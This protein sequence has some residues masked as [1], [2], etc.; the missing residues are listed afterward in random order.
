MSWFDVAER[1]VGLDENTVCRQRSRGLHRLRG[2][3]GAAVEGDR[4]SHLHES[5]GLLRVASE[6]VND[7]QR[8][9]LVCEA[10]L[11][12]FSIPLLSLK[13]LQN[14]VELLSESV[15]V[16]GARRPNRRKMPLEKGDEVVEGGSTVKEHRQ[17]RPTHQFKL[18]LEVHKLNVFRAELQS[19]FIQ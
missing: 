4:E 16:S 11:S 9:L 2:S 7:S 14:G 3:E 6:A 17:T 19:I 15:K 8:R 18:T 1:R 10:L 12:L 5:G 13:D